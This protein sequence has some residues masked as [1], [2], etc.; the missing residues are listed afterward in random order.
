MFFPMYIMLYLNNLFFYVSEV[1]IQ[2]LRL[3]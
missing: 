3:D 2:P 1:D